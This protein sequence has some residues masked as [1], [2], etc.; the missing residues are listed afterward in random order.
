MKGTP[1]SGVRKKYVQTYLA[2]MRNTL[3]GMFNHIFDTVILQKIK[4]DN[5]EHLALEVERHLFTIPLEILHDGQDYLC[6]E[7][8]F[9]R[10]ITPE[11]GQISSSE[12]PKFVPKA[13][14]EGEPLR[15]L[16]VD[17]RL[18]KIPP[19]SREDFG[20]QLIRFLVAKGSLGK[21]EVAV[22]TARGEL[23][24]EEVKAI[25]SSA[26]YDIIHMIGPAEIS[27]GDPA[28]S[29]WVFSNGE[30]R[31]YEL[32]ELFAQGYPQLIVSHVSSPPL[33]REWDAGQ[34]SRII[35][36]LALSALA[37][38]TEC[39]V[40]EVAQKLTD[41][42]LL[43][44][45]DLY[46]KMLKDKKPIGEALRATRLNFIKANSMEDDGWMKPV[47]YGNPAKHIS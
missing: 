33:E 18:K 13:H 19:V 30:I 28:G 27:S 3:V 42:E 17:S 35:H 20:G 40:G 38:G 41:S 4:E 44:T 8:S 26:K 36:A 46:R 1:E 15:I 14:R 11:Q 10:W 5:P 45:T 32:A 2:E 24:K 12:K 43:M 47:L 16:I 23:R 31:G 25:L 6:L 29:S 39:F 21:T 7:R 22:E 37:A 34:E 9:S